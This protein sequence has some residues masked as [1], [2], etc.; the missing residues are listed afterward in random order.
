MF[1]RIIVGHDHHAGGQDALALGHL[2]AE[3]TGAELIVAGVIPMG[4][5][6]ID[7][8]VLFRMQ[9]RSFTDAISERAGT[10]GAEPRVYHSQ[11][12]ARGLNDL[13]DEAGAD[14]I[15]VGSSRRGKVGQVL[16]GHIALQLLHGSRCA[17]AVAPDG[18]AD[19]PPASL[20]SIVVG[21]D[22]AREAQAAAAAAV[23][24]AGATGASVRL[25][26]VQQAPA[27]MYGPGAVAGS[28]DKL[29]AAI[30]GYLQHDLDSAAAAFPADAKP[31]TEL[32]D[33][34]PGELLRDAASEASLLMLGSRGF[35]PLGRVVLGSTDARLLKAAPCPVLV[36][37]RRAGQPERASERAP[38]PVAG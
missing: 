8:E 26:A 7:T 11:S 10:V 15:V 24:V 6:L 1:S 29:E 32:L 5:A 12:V 3:A 18:Y 33:G 4:P 37:P 28:H 19:D 31:E 27:V 2:L 36:W 22:G 34:D 17:V 30:R 23:D 9:S 38:E 20:D 25:V 13:A 21:V 35:G 16:A 14:L